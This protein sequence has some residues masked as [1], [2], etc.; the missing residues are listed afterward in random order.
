MNNLDASDNISSSSGS[1]TLNLTSS[2][3]IDSSILVNSING[4]ETLNMS[5]GNDTVSFGS[6][7]DFTAFSSEFTTSINANGGNDTLSFGST[8]INADL[9]FSHIS[10]FEN[11]NL[12]G[13]ADSL[14]ISGDEAKNINGLGGDDTFSLDF[15]NIGNFNIDGGANN[16]KI[17]FN[18]N[19]GISISSDG[20]SLFSSE[21]FTHIE[22]LDISNLNGGAGFSSDDNKEFNF[23]SEMLDKWIG[24]NQGSLKLTLTAAQAEDISFTDSI[25]NSQRNTTVGTGDDSIVTGT[26]YS[27]DNDTTLIIDIV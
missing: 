9:D 17:E 2:G 20:D 6:E 1:D 18:A 11:I 15:S 21:N 3:S 12:S 23:T 19:T 10:G 27:L 4:F 24:S 16:D 22:E 7:S 25:T 14:I 26:T 5:S 13:G 8:L